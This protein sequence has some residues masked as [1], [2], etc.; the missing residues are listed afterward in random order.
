MVPL[1][2][3]KEKIDQAA[4]YWHYPHYHGAGGTPSSAIRKGDWKLIQFYEDNHIEL[5]NLRTDIEER[6]NL[7]QLFPQKVAGMLDLLNM[8]RR[9]THAR[10]PA[11]NPYY[12]PNYEELINQRKMTRG[13]YMSQYD[14]LFDKNIFDPAL[15][16][17]IMERDKMY[18]KH[19]EGK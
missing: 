8:W 10:I 3:G 9:K 1:L 12:N 17:S 6:R 19:A 18:I 14:A 2:K 16:K 7:V 4:I 5:Y 11:I 15:F 13:R